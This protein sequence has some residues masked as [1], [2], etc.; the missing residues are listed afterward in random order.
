MSRGEVG[1]K[2]AWGVGN[3]TSRCMWKG[4]GA[5]DGVGRKWGER[6]G[7]WQ[8]EGGWVGRKDG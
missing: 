8:R 1:R 3:F 6:H 5:S 7:D 2:G 4:G